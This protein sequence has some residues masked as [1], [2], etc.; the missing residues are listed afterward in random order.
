MTPTTVPTPS[1]SS[2]RRSTDTWRSP[3]STNTSPIFITAT[4]TDQVATWRATEPRRYGDVMRDR[5]ITVTAL[6][7]GDL[8]ADL[9]G[10]RWLDGTVECRARVAHVD[11]PLAAAG[12]AVGVVLT[13][14]TVSCDHCSEA[15]G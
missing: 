2:Q 12:D 9:T 13:D 11:G 10:V 3:T 6:R 14:P 7:A 15:C 4:I 1:K 8:P 5:S